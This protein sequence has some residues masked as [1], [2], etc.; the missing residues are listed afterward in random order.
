[1]P[2]GGGGSR[3]ACREFETEGGFSYLLG[4]LT[5]EGYVRIGQTEGGFCFRCSQSVLH[6]APNSP[7]PAAGHKPKKGDETDS[8]AGS[9]RPQKLTKR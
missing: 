2:G 5:N 8:T 9:K 1:M 6:T 7:T 3:V 4:L